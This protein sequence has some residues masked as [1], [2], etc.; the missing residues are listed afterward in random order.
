[1]LSSISQEMPPIE[2]NSG[3]FDHPKSPE[4]HS[5]TTGWVICRADYLPLALCILSLAGCGKEHGA[6]YYECIALSGAKSQATETL[7]EVKK[8]CNQIHPP[9][10]A[11]DAE[12]KVIGLNLVKPAY[13]WQVDI[14]NQSPAF[15]VTEIVVEVT[16]ADGERFRVKFQAESAPYAKGGSA[17]EFATWDGKYSW[18][19]VS[20]KGRDFR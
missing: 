8:A 9:R 14:D 4:S 10:H 2:L 5:K 17:Q 13:Y 1:M 16:K 12:K 7:H 18:T 20:L 3:S 15:L 11:T 6:N 19:L